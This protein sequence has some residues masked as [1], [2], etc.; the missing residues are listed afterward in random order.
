[1]KLTNIGGK[2]MKKILFG[3]VLAF[4]TLVALFLFQNAYINFDNFN[5]GK[6]LSIKVTRNFCEASV[7]SDTDQMIVITDSDEIKSIE[8]VFFGKISNNLLGY[9]KE[10]LNYNFE[11]HYE[12]TTL[13]FNVGIDQEFS[14]GKIKYF[15]RQRDYPLSSKDMGIIKNI[16]ENHVEDN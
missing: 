9:T 8:S 16:L 4:F 1:M 10:E 13:K 11:F 5:G 3:I 14:S 12:K 2:F 15:A 6:L 7:C